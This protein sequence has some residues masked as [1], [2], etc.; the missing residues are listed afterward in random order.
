MRTKSR[1]VI[2]SM[3]NST[4]KPRGKVWKRILLGAFAVMFLTC[5][6]VPQIEKTT[7]LPP[8]IQTIHEIQEQVTE[9]PALEEDLRTR[10]L[11]LYGEAL[12]ALTEAQTHKARA[13]GYNEEVP[14]INQRLESL[15][16]ELSGPLE[17]LTVPENISVERLNGMLKEELDRWDLYEEYEDRFLAIFRK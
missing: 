10:L 5:W 13:A 1:G 12:N 3:N 14:S 6:S 4:L 15:Q 9:D 8:T 7:E 11:A 16:A 17:K 2:Q